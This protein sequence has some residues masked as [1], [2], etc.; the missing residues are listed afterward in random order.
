[1]AFLG[2][3]FRFATTDSD[4][5]VHRFESESPNPAHQ[6][7]LVQDTAANLAEYIQEMGVPPQLFI[8]M[9]KTPYDQ[10]RV[11]TQKEKEELQVVTGS[12]TPVMW[13][14]SSVSGRLRLTGIRNT[15]WGKQLVLFECTNMGVQIQIQFEPKKR[16]N[17][18]KI[19]G[20][21][22]LYIGNRGTDPRPFGSKKP[23][24]E[25]GMATYWYR[26]PAP[27]LAAFETAQD[28]SFIS[29]A[30]QESDLF[31]GIQDF[32]LKGALDDLKAVRNCTGKP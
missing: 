28:F 23:A 10:V 27:L 18:L 4:Y 17:D 26:L 29:R 8:L 24:F 25:D 14:L 21:H 3:V 13:K 32:P 7:A 9:E 22:E 2:G 11:L 12:T 31:L 5:G 6:V 15:F 16:E 30:T 19:H 1:L 20:V